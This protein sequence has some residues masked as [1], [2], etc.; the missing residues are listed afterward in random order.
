M[1]M[2]LPRE[3]YVPKGAVKVADKTSDAVAYVYETAT[4]KPGAV[5]FHGKAQ[6]PDA[7]HTFRTAERRA[8]YVAGFFAGRRESLERK[9]KARAERSKPHTLKV[10]DIL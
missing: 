3:F 7:H 5:V 10:G 4:G 8:E 9:A 1:R 2:Q 6:K